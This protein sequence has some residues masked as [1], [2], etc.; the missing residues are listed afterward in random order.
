[1]LKIIHGY[2]SSGVGGKLR[3]ALRS[4]LRR[5][6]RKG[7][8]VELVPGEDWTLANDTA[9]SVITRIPALKSDKELGKHNKGITVVILR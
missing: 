5:L 6:A 3:H 1:M 2:G 9:R 7:E 4:P 8:I